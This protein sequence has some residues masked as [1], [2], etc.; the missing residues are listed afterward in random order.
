MLQTDSHWVTS[1]VIHVCAIKSQ[2]QYHNVLLLTNR[3]QNYRPVDFW[4]SVIFLGATCFVIG[5]V[6]SYVLF[7]TIDQNNRDSQLIEYD[8]DFQIASAFLH[9]ISAAS[10]S[11]FVR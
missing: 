9:E 11:K 10:I 7:L 5:F 3:P 1:P 4:S 2:S 6:V 8:A